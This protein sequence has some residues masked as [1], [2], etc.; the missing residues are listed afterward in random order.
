LIRA[1]ISTA[2]RQI[3]ALCVADRAALRDL[4]FDDDL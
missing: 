1:S 3:A 4:V 2:E